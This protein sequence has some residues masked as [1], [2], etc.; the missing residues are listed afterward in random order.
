MPESHTIHRWIQISLKFS[1]L[2]G[3]WVG[4]KSLALC[5]LSD[6][7]DGASFSP[8]AGEE[9]PGSWKHLRLSACLHTETTI[10]QAGNCK[11]RR[12]VK[13]PG[14]CLRPEGCVCC[15]LTICQRDRWSLTVLF[16]CTA[17]EASNFALPEQGSSFPSSVLI[18]RKTEQAEALVLHYT[19]S[20]AQR[21]YV[22]LRYSLTYPAGEEGQNVV[23]YFLYKQPYLLQ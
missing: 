21:L 19:G 13:S 6:Y 2:L 22:W 7:G 11:S 18:L 14:V 3:I 9:R 5:F 23:A 8:W 4:S 17:G 10:H 20:C 1:E 16:A 15:V 12:Q